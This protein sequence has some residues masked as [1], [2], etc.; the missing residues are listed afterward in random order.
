MT[1][2]RPSDLPFPW[3]A[4]GATPED[5]LD[6]FATEAESAADVLAYAAACFAYADAT[7]EALPGDAAGRVPW[8][9]PDREPVTLWQILVH[10]ALDEARHAGHA[11]ILREQI[12]GSAGRRGPGENLPD[13]DAAG[14]AAYRDR[15]ARIADGLP[16]AGRA[17]RLGL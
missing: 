4:P 13:W 8:W 2:G 16:C 11:D 12:D 1:F 9:P 14:W 15:L 5:N 7:I 10:V 17:P 6:M 3:E